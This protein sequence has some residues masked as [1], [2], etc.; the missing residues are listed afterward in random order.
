MTG[1]AFSIE[2]V[3]F[4]YSEVNGEPR[5]IF[6][7]LDAVILP[8][9]VTAIMGPSG[10]GKST[11]GKLL[12]GELKPREGTVMLGSGLEEESNRFYVD[13]DPSRVYFPWKTVIGNLRQ[14]LSLMGWS[15]ADTRQRVD[16]LMD[17]MDLRAV[18]ERFPAFLSG[19]QK[20]RLAL[21]RV[22]S[23]RPRSLILDEYLADLDVVTRRRVVDALRR[24]V[25]E[26]GMTLVMIS[27]D[28]TDVA[29]L[30]DRCLVLSGSPARVLADID[31]MGKG[32]DGAEAEFQQ[33]IHQSLMA[34][35]S[36]V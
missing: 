18:A 22:L 36:T 15:E 8:G 16:E 17:E 19:G 31:W 28:P 23:W 24:Y 2:R 27:H 14:P 25:R 1:S 12:A 6:D 4:S 30:A 13:Q 20:S 11:L 35:M 32:R 9:C 7:G 26:E 34:Q 3:S 29:S 10:A 21:A 33:L 5:N